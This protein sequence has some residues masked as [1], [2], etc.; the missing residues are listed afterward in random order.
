MAY[1]F[2]SHSH[3][4][5]PFAR[6]LAANL[7]SNGHSVWIDEAE[8]NIGD[9]LI[10]KI[11]EGLDKVDYV[12]ALLSKSSI[13][14]QWVQKELDIASNREID[15]KR[16]MVLPLLISDV[17]LPGFL[18]GK[19]YGDFRDEGRYEEVFE[20]LLRAVGGGN[21]VNEASASEIEALRIALSHAQEQVDAHQRAAKRAENAAFRAKSTGLKEAIADA[22]R[23]FP[24]HATINNTYAFEVA[25]SPITLDYLL[26]AIAKAA[27]KGAHPLD[28]LISLTN[29]WEDVESM[30]Q[31]YSEMVE[32]S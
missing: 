12:C 29:Q 20:A 11:R 23:N 21:K 22:N 25:D 15:E 16:V 3:A 8:I 19:F 14:S 6:K 26:W 1:I 7:R 10:G 13:D 2:L 9:S 24:H 18:R 32:R 17:E 4:D 31:A 27:R 28:A 30:L 5:K